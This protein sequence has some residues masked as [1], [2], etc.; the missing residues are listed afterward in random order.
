MQIQSRVCNSVYI[1]IRIFILLLHSGLFLGQ[2]KVSTLNKCSKVL[3][4][5]SDGK[6]IC[7]QK[8]ASIEQNLCWFT[9]SLATGSSQACCLRERPFRYSLSCSDSG[10]HGQTSSGKLDWQIFWHVLNC[11]RFY[12]HLDG[13]HRD[14]SKFRTLQMELITHLKSGQTNC[15]SIVRIAD[16]SRFWMSEF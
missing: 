14:K 7:G 1:L 6:N 10:V 2:T 4:V 16:K 8:R 15:F 13:S 3:I 5:W 12:W 9:E 11:V